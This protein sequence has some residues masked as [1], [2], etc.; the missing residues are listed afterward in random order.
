MSG[1]K[2][3]IS[4]G[5]TGGHIYPAIAIAN[6]LKTRDKDSQILFVGANGKMEMEK[7]PKAGYNIEGLNISGFKRSLD[8]SNV[9]LPVKVWMSLKKAGHIIKKFSPDAVIGTG[10]FAS[11]PV[12][13]KAAGY[14]IPTLIQEQ[15]SFPGV[16]NKIL[17]KRV[18]KICVA[19]ENMNEYFPKEKIIVSGNPVRGELRN[20]EA[21]KSACL[22]Y[23]GLNKDKKTILSIGGSLGAKGINEALA[24]SLK[25]FQDNDIQL[26]WQTGKPFYD[27]AKSASNGM[28]NIKAVEF[29]YEMGKAYKVADIIIS[30]AGAIAISELCLIGKPT[31][32]IPYP[33]ATGNHQFKNAESL[34][35]NNATILIEDENAGEELLPALIKLVGDENKQKEIASNIAQMAKPEALTTIVNEIEKLVA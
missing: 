20:E 2:Y 22:E 9:S 11:G 27:Q 25:A 30:R 28:K 24:D 35:K 3:I 8:W 33:Y 31:I 19:Y 23:F 29:I 13:F 18:N 5:G 34:S 6:E 14:S 12:L 4:G 17:A 32:L 15:N 16:T 10:G 26:L 1:K 21:P 7:V